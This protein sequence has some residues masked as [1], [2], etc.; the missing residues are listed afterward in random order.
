MSHRS[1]NIEVVITMKRAMAVL[2]GML[3]FCHC[4]REGITIYAPPQLAEAPI[5]IDGKPAGHFQKTQRLYRWVGWRKMKD[6]LNAP[7][8]SETIAKLS[9]V[10]VGDHEL[11]I[12]KAGYLPIE[13][14]FRYSAE[15]LEIEIEDEEMKPI[16]S[17][18][19]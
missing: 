5:W 19:P 6:E 16:V 18:T 11:R 15:Q 3:L 8:R 10:A 9:P 17:S 12:E 4:A 1:S 14:S 2:L 7:P 13:K